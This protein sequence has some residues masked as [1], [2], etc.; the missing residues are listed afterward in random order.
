[1]LYQKLK[2]VSWRT[3]DRDFFE[4]F[5]ELKHL[6]Q[7]EIYDRFVDLDLDLYYIH[8]RNSVSPLIRL[9]LPFAIVL[10]IIM[11]L[12]LPINFLF[13]GYWGY[14]VSEK[15]II[16]NWFIMLFGNM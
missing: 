16:R 2:S 11:F 8:R 9:T 3:F 4:K 15:S 14:R 10:M 12:Y 13:T 5:P 7:H 1:M 6:T